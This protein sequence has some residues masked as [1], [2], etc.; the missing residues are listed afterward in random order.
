MLLIIIEKRVDCFVF[1]VL[2]NDLI[3]MFVCVGGC[4]QATQH[5]SSFRLAFVEQYV[6]CIQHLKGP[7]FSIL[8]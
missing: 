2:G 8:S 1:C 4:W 7:T 6:F 3:Q 5:F